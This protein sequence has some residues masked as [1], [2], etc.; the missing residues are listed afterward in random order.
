ME[1]EKYGGKA[2]FWERLPSS[3]LHE[4]KSVCY[5]L[6]WIPTEETRKAIVFTICALSYFILLSRIQIYSLLIRTIIR[7]VLS[8]K[9]QETTSLY[10]WSQFSYQILLLVHEFWVILY[11]SM[12]D[13]Y[14]LTFTRSVV[15]IKNES[16]LFKLF[17]LSLYLVQIL[18]DRMT[19]FKT[20]EYYMILCVNIVSNY[21]QSESHRK[22][23]IH[24]AAMIL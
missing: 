19:R 11:S 24:I 15:M 7:Y 23:V 9:E 1:Y 3:T 18:F 14:S 2:W 10:H 16:L 17:S 12:M 8:T 5:T 21:L 22:N 13:Y 4:F 20:I 6:Y